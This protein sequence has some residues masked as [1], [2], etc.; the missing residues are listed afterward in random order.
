MDAPLYP[1]LF[2]PVYKDYLWGGDRIARQFHRSDTPARCAESWELADRSEGMSIIINGVFKGKSLESLVREQ[3]PRLLG[4]ETSFSRFP[5]LIKLI[6]ARL[7]LS[8]QVHPNEE[9]ARASGGEPKTEMWYILAAEPD[10]RIFAGLKPGIHRNLFRKAV[11]EG[12]LD[13]TQLAIIPAKPGRAFFVPGGK[14]HAIGAGCLLLEVQ[15][16]SNTTY[17]IHDW[18]R[19]D[20]NGQPRELHIQQALQ[21]IQWDRAQPEICSP[22]PLPMTGDNAFSHILEC[23]YF[24]IMKIRLAGSETCEHD[25]RSFHIIFV[26]NGKVLAGA[27]GSVA[28]IESGTTCLIPADASPYTLTPVQGPANLIRITL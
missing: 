27:K 12:S 6:D 3:G 16:N 7:D 9:T 21:T 5:L 17:R 13:E 25:K 19:T 24:K 10:A 15:Q 20:E 4:C 8:L 18:N 28:V 1:M 11:A 23:P 26:I 22:K 14:P 2:Q